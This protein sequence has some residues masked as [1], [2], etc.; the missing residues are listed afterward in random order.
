MS[1]C[2]WKNIGRLQRWILWVLCGECG[3][4]GYSSQCKRSASS[5]KYTQQ[6]A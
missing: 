1:A 2:R 4:N 6:K 5:V 3:C